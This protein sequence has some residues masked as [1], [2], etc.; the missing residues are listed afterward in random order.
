VYAL[1]LPGHGKSAGRG[2]Q[3]IAGYA[4]AVT[5]WL[6][7]TG[8][9]SGIFVGHSMGS[10]IV[11][12]LALDFPDHVLG[13]GLVGAGGRLPVGPALLEGTANPT[14]FS[15]AVEVI[16]SSSFSAQAPE[17][18]TRTATQQMAET[19]PA[20]LHGDFL[21]CDA[22]DETARISG[23][24]RPTL[25]ITG[26]E[27]R[28]TPVRQAQF[29]AGAIPN[30]RL[31]VVPEAGHMVMLEQPQVVANALLRFFNEIPY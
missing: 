17:A 4:A 20:V 18:L 30:A 1:D 15:Q 23:I 8:L 13:L 14:M 24:Q 12:S 26:A 21:A 27:D 3:S 25:V 19:R 5:D 9:H 11:L 28:M 29:L 10:A 2:Q 22:F 31:E 16:V 7:A 6:E